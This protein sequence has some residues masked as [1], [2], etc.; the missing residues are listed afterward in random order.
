VLLLL[1]LMTA[2]LSHLLL[3]LRAS[4]LGPVPAAFAMVVACCSCSCCLGQGSGE[5]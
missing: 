3:D 4:A 5:E 1:E 2:Q